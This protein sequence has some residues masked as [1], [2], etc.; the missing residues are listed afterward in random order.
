[1]FAVGGGPQY[2]VCAKLGSPGGPGRP[3]GAEVQRRAILL[4]ILLVVLALFYASV[5]LDRVPD[6][7][8]SQKA[9]TDQFN[10]LDE[11]VLEAPDAVPDEGKE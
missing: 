4:L 8:S 11:Q 3:E 1:M 7:V 5:T 9:Q 6:I 10:R 2:R